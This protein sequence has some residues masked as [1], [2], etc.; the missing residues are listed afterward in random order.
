MYLQTDPSIYCGVLLLSL[1]LCS[2]SSHLILVAKLC[3]ILYCA[4][5]RV[6]V[7]EG[8]SGYVFV[9]AQEYKNKN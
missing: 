6:G 5:V 8:G 9:C 7:G 4:C 2:Y 1:N 3:L